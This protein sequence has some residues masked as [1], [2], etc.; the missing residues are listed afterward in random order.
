MHPVG[1]QTQQEAVKKMCKE[2]G[3]VRNFTNHS[4]RVIAATRLYAAGVDEQLIAEKT[5]H[6]SNAIRAYKRT[7]DKQQMKL[8]K[9]LGCGNDA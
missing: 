8:S 7:C 3:I 1:V 6:R 5:G 4:L 2:G 9:I